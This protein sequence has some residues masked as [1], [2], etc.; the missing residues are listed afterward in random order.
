MKQIAE[1]REMSNEDLQSKAAELKEHLFRL[2]FKQSL[3]D[4]EA[5][6]KIAKERKQLARVK[7]LL[8]AR[9][10]GNEK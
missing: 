9:A 6:R 8:R 3:G 7:T 4:V 2:R 5:V 10:L 1:L